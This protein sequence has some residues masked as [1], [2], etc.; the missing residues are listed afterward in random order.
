VSA[1]PH[2]ETQ[3][4]LDVS[5]IQPVKDPS[6]SYEWRLI[7]D[8][9]RLLRYASTAKEIDIG[10]DI[11]N[12]AT[13]A[14]ETA[15]ASAKNGHL[16]P[17]DAHSNL[18]KSVDAITPKVYPVTT[19]SLEIAEIM[20]IGR[21]G[22]S[23]RQV[24]IRRRVDALT[25]RWIWFAIAALGLV[26]IMTA[27]TEDVPKPNAPHGWSSF[28]DAIYPYVYPFAEFVNPIIL[29]FLGSC[30]YILRS[31]LQGLANQTF[32]LRDG[33][34]YTLR[35]ILG[36]ILGFMILNLVKDKQGTLPFLSAVTIPFLAGYAVEPMFAALDNIVVTIRDAVGRDPA[37]HAGKGK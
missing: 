12:A 3:S 36:M 26:F 28:I 18:L 5:P 1:N 20:E 7:Y 15:E 32:V 21:T 23:P 9:E 35:S 6:S 33:T 29:G 16:L 22:L 30:A 13:K 14:L 19:A 31:I 10:S 8:L 37:P 2:S 25:T 11:L 27:I 34:T 4:N 17:P 24:E